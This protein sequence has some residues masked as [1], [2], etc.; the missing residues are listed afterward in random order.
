MQT[1]TLQYFKPVLVY[2][3]VSSYNYGNMNFFK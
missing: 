2:I 1:F 3:Y